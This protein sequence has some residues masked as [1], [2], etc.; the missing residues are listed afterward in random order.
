MT[1]QYIY[2]RSEREFTNILNQT[3]P[4][5]FGFMAL[6]SGMD[7]TLKRDVKVHCEDC[8]RLFQTDGQSVPMRFFRK[9]R[10]PKGQILLQESTWIEKGGRDFHV[11]HGYVLDEPAMTAGPAKWLAA[12][13]RLEDPNRIPGGIPPL[14]SLSELPGQELSKLHPLRDAAL[15]LGMESYCQ[16]LL[17]CFDAVVSRRQ[18]LIAWDFEQSGEWELRR[19]VL[20]WIY[21]F[22]PY[23]M[24]AGLGFDSVY[25]DKS[26]PGLTHLAFVDRTLI[27]DKG[28]TPGIQLGNQLLS[29][30]GNFLV[31]NG[32]IIHNDGKYKTEWYGQSF[33]YAAWLKRLVDMVWNSPEERRADVLQTLED[34]R[35][36]L[37]HEMRSVPEAKRLNAETCSKASEQVWKL[38]ERKE[39]AVPTKPNPPKVAPGPAAVKLEPPKATPASQKVTPEPSAV[40]P[41]PFKAAPAPPKDKPAAVPAREH[42]PSPSEVYQDIFRRRMWPPSPQDLNALASMC[43]EVGSDAI[44]LLSAFMAREVDASKWVQIMSVLGRYQGLPGDVY[45]QLLLRLFWD[46]LT[47]KERAVWSE[48]GVE[49]GDEAAVRR[50]CKY[51]SAI[52]LRYKSA[53]SFTEYVRGFLYGLPGFSARQRNQMEKECSQWMDGYFQHQFGEILSRRT[54]PADSKDIQFLA[55]VPNGWARASALGILGAFMA[56][57]ADALVEYP[58]WTLNGFSVLTYYQVWMQQPA[59]CNWLLSRLFWNRMSDVERNAWN[60]CDV[61]N[62]DEA[63]QNRRYKWYHDILLAYMPSERAA[64]YAGQWIRSITGISEQDRAQMINELQGEIKKCAGLL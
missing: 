19:S 14:E 2:S 32:E 38:L 6:S 37:Q 16:L 30:G 13:F 51:Y 22:L 54:I 8:P 58:L 60:K 11:A 46:G 59:V 57:D 12:E 55:S 56:R 26:S 10:L 20:Y 24:W 36:K 3:I 50:R 23:D 21:A 40:K 25:T 41:E 52:A 42:G 17:A 9:A 1:E 62:S 61:K 34:A 47:V 53:E 18:V 45:S 43:G 31:K 28:K 64:S 4:L 35:E 39:T 63:A 15:G 49:S 29:L 27:Q 44:G 48:C 7:N 5:G 33:R